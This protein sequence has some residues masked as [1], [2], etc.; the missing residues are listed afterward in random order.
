MDAAARGARAISSSD[1]P[2]AISSYT[3]ALRTNPQAV[4]YYIKRSTAYTRISPSNPL[5]ALS[6]AETAVVLANKRGK[7]ELIAQGQLRRGIA[8]FSCDRWA[9]AGQCFAWVKELDPKERTLSIWNAKVEDKLKELGEEDEQRKIK[10]KKL[11]DIDVDGLAK[12]AAEASKKPEA[13]SAAPVSQPAPPVGVQT[14]PGQIR[15][16]WYQSTDTV[17]ITLMAKGVP[18]D[19]ATVDI[20]PR[21]LAISFPL[22][23]G[24]DYDFTLDPFF[25]EIDPSKST[26][27]VMSTKVEFILKKAT[28]GHKWPSLEGDHTSSPLVNPSAPTQQL[29]PQPAAAKGPIYPTSSKSGPKDWDKL[30][31]D[32]TKK[33]KGEDGAEDDGYISDDGGDPANAFFKKLYKDADPDTRRA[34]MKSYQESNGTALS[35]NWSEVSKKPIETSPPDGMVAKKWGE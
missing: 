1:F 31:T 24:N 30:A 35:T 22:P 2:T 33:K 3:E 18:K 25:A 26:H 4:D 10:V 13:K 17:T 7:R 34:M 11:P 5:L 27:K 29:K 28:P 8:L 23:T 21:S 19:Q 9:D 15:H 14:A 20:Q 16:D 12:K 6:D 32:L